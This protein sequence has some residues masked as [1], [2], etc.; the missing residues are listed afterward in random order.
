[1]KKIIPIIMSGGKGTRLWPVS[2]KSHAKQYKKIINDNSL[3]EETLIRI[4][5]NKMNN[6]I[7]ITNKDDLFF[8]NDSLTKLNILAEVILEPEGKGTAPA[9]AIAAHKLD[10]DDVI[11]IL[12]SDHFIEDS[13]SFNSQILKAHKMAKKGFLVTFG[14][15]PTYPNTGYGYIKKGSSTEIEDCFMIDSFKEKPSKDVAEKYLEDKDYFWNSGIFMF[16]A[17]NYLDELNIYSPKIYKRALDTLENSSASDNNLY[18][19]KDFFDLCPEDSIDY[20]VLEKTTKSV[21][22]QCDIGWTDVGTWSSVHDVSSKDK[23]NNSKSNNILSISS[24]NNYIYTNKLTTLLGVNDLV[25]VDTADALLITDHN[26]SQNI[27]E[28]VEALNIA[29]KDEANIGRKVYRPWGA[30]DS[31]S[32]GPGFQVKVITVNPGSKLSVQKHF[33]RSEHWTVV[34]GVAEVTKGKKIFTLNKNESTYIEIEEIH[35]L[36][37]PGSEELVLIEVQCGSYLGED[38]IVRYEDIYGRV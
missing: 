33:K 21:M 7:I 15:K 19:N 11:L 20:A 16:T 13:E 26:N 12:S 30:Y 37:N 35:A 31:I 24:K 32:S 9:I 38:D 18:L 22:I 23:N 34:S 36:A 14:I 1:M 8:V 17:G 5:S 10:P 3:L 25:V 2:R 27:G 6:P 28:I 4:S 29:N